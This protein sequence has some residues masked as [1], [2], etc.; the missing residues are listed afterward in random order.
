MTRIW[1]GPYTETQ[2][3]QIQTAPGYFIPQCKSFPHDFPS[4][5]RQ[6]KLVRYHS[7]LARIVQIQNHMGSSTPFRSKQ[8]DDCIPFTSL[9]SFP[10]CCILGA[11]YQTE[12]TYQSCLFNNTSQPPRWERLRQHMHSRISPWE[13]GGT[14]LSKRCR[15]PTMVFDFPVPG[16]PWM[17]QTLGILGCLTIDN[18]ML[19]AL[20][21]FTL[22]SFCVGKNKSDQPY[23]KFTKK[24]KSFTI[25]LCF[26]ICRAQC[27]KAC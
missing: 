11:V 10:H 20:C 1:I 3:L 18:A 19:I 25:M 6:I 15:S 17:R 26:T 27:R 24:H 8:A 9:Y 22:Y 7:S 21:W 5:T 2:W 4:F 14:S 12:G 16:G 13:N 23:L